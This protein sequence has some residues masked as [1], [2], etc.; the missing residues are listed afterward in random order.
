[1][2]EQRVY[3][4]QVMCPARHCIFALTG[5]YESDDAAA[6]LAGMLKQQFDAMLAS[7]L[8][9]PRCGVCGGVDFHV[10]VGRTRWRTLIEAYPHLMASEQEQAAGRAALKAQRN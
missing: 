1:M 7:D 10:E 9:E 5:E 3:I 6:I 8:V 4:G 2:N